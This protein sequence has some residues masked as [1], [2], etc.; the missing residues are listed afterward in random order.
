MTIYFC[1]KRL[2][3]VT[4]V[5]IHIRGRLYSNFDCFLIISGTQLDGRTDSG[6]AVAI[7]G[8][9]AIQDAVFTTQSCWCDFT[10]VNHQVFYKLGLF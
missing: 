3:D 5:K 1:F 2:I 10:E 6:M 4:Q 7:G 9:A 8:P